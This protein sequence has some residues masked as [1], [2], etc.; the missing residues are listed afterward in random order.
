VKSELPAYA[1]A[2]PPAI[3]HLDMD[4][5]YASVEQRDFPEMRGKPVIVGG[6]PTRGVVLAASYEVRPSGVRSAMSMAVATRLAPHAIVVLPRMAA[7]QNAS[8]EVFRIL[9]SVTPLVEPLSLDEAFLD[10]TGSV[11]L[12]GP[13][14]KI[15]RALRARIAAEVG[16][17]SSAGIAAVKFAAKIASDLAKPNGQKEVPASD[18]RGFIAP[19]PVS[20][21]WGVGRKTEATLLGLGLRRIGDIAAAD[22]HWLEQCV[23]AGRA[24]WE[25]ACGIDPR[26][27]VPDRE[28]KSMGAEVTFD[29]D[30]AD[31]A[32]M[33]P[34]LHA[35][36]LRVGRRLRLATQKATV[37]HL[38]VKMADFTVRT[39][40][41]TLKTPT[42]DGQVIYQVAASL[43][44]AEPLA[45]KVRLIGVSA[46][47]FEGQGG[48]LPL[49]G[50]DRRATDLNRALDGIAQRFGEAAVTTADLAATK[51]RR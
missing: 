38:K 27:V 15:A 51:Q 16:L 24:L 19:L 28:A 23:P 41:T 2:V 20:R 50:N 11:G 22:P 45:E 14:S 34:H 48:Q 3:I 43:L 1:R 25:L 30:L 29:E 39:R 40:Q 7:Y 26:P 36:S 33:L 31:K 12:F 46:Q 42:D 4:A 49:F 10:V 18:T 44:D 8:D 6:H 47:G 21:L 5:F 35:Q 32:S 17:P 13:P 9:G 37:I